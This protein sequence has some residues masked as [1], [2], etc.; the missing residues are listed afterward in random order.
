MRK[1]FTPFTLSS[2]HFVL[3]LVGVMLFAFCASAEAQQV[4]KV[5]RIGVLQRS[6]LPASFSEAF[7]GGLR[8]LGYV[9]GR[10]IVIENRATDEG[11][12]EASATELVR[13]GIDVIVA[14]GTGAVGD[15]K[16]ATTT[17]PIV[18]SPSADA[19]AAGLVESLARPGGNVTGLTMISPDLSGKRIELLKEAVP[20]VTRIAAV[21]ALDGRSTAIEPWLNETQS[22]AKALGLRFQK[23]G[24][25]EDANTWGDAFKEVA[26]ESGSALVVI[27]NARLISNRNRIAELAARH[28]L[29]T[30]FSVKEH[31]E[32]GG[33]LSYG[34]DLV[35]VHRR[36]ATYVDKILKGRKPSELP[37][38]QPM[39]FEF[40]INLRTAKQIALTIPPNVLARADRVIR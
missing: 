4:K 30:M 19:V 34:P 38:E 40:V 31:V 18:M 27:E 15:A 17:I 16:K 28:Q 1:K 32:A 3:C 24:V 20:S 9:E 5:Y 11:R 21:F 22:G 13:L 35:D 36:A 25:R 14:T 39:K 7:R 10:N 6:T 12:S 8:E 37:V 29:P 23:V 26:K 33:L 2:L